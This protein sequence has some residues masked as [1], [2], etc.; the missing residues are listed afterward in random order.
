[1][2]KC[3]FSGTFDPPTTGHKKIIEI[4]LE[5]FDEVVVALMFNTDKLPLF[6]EEERV[7]MLKKLFAE[8]KRVKVR[9]FHGAAVDLLEE[10]NTSFYVRG[11]RN[12]LDFEY[13]NTNFFA[14]RKLKNDIITIYIPCDQQN[15][16]VSSTLVRNSIKFEKD[17]SE[18]VPDEIKEDILKIS[19]NKHV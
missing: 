14:N 11:V 10:E 4:C 13:E 15:L 12:T 1:M 19:E 6:S 8:E 2:K 5:L 3:V 9:T 7:G 16:H 17:Y 18:Y